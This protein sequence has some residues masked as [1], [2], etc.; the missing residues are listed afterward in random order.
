[1]GERVKGIGGGWGA[2]LLAVLVG[3][4]QPLAQAF[5]EDEVQCE[6]MAAH[7]ADCCDNFDPQ[8]IDCEYFE[9][10]MSDSYPSI[11]V[12]ESRCIRE[13]SCKQVREQGICERVLARQ[14]AN[15]TEYPADEAVC[16]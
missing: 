14:S 13:K 4:A 2:A 5:R 8:S 7:L 11:T 1:M 3:G 6:E 10:C 12:D 15:E 16:R 9:G